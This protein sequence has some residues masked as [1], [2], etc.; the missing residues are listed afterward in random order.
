M[1]NKDTQQRNPRDLAAAS[2]SLGAKDRPNSLSYRT[3]QQSRAFRRGS[4]STV[5]G[6]DRAF[7]RTLR[8]VQPCL[9]Q[10]IDLPLSKCDARLFFLVDRYYN[11]LFLQKSMM[12]WTGPPAKALAHLSWSLSTFRGSDKTGSQGSCSL[13]GSWCGLSSL[14]LSLAKTLPLPSSHPQCSA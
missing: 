13:T 2:Q 5:H 6:V 7:P 1:N 3:F 9:V 11:K 8:M 4:I 10:L 14:Y 12:A